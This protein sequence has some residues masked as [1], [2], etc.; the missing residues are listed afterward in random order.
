[1]IALRQSLL[2]AAVLISVTG[3]SSRGDD[4]AP[5]VKQDAAEQGLR[6]RAASAFRSRLAARVPE[7]VRRPPGFPRRAG[8]RRA[9]VAQPGR[10][11]LR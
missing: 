11:G 6:G 9:A 2:L 8:R 10:H 5:D 3:R 1:M 7:A 4:K